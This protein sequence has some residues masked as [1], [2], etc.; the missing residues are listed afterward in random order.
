MKLHFPLYAKILIWFFLNLILLGIAFLVLFS[1]QFPLNLNWFL[2]DT[3]RER[4]DSTRGLIVGDLNSRPQ[5]EWDR[6]LARY[7]EAYRVQFVLYAMDGTRLAGPEVELPGEVRERMSIRWRG[8]RGF[9]GGE[10]DQ[11]ED[12]LRPRFRPWPGQILV[13][14]DAPVRYWLLMRARLDGVGATRTNRVF[15]VAVSNRLTG[16]GLFLDIKPWL[17]LGLGV[18]AFSILFW[19]PF[20]RGITRSIGQMTLATRRIA[21]GH[22]DV[23]V[24]AQRGDELGSLAESINQ[25]AERLNGFVRG[26]KRFLGDVAHELCAPLAKLQMALGIL[27]QQ[28]GE[29]QSA[30]VRAASEKAAQISVLVEELLSFSR[31]GYDMRERKLT[32]TRLRP[33]IEDAIRRE[34]TEGVALEIDCPDDLAAQGDPELLQRA[35]GNLIRNALQHGGCEGK[36]EIRALR[37]GGQVVVRVMDEGP[38][39]P[40]EEI[41]KLFDAFYRVDTSRTR[42]TGGTGLGL[43]IVKQCVEACGGTVSAANRAPRG[44]EV[45]LRLQI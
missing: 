4:I 42:D 28:A 10:P 16:G 26:Q 27:E 35:L 39:V 33:L 23:R 9:A 40:A 13:R 19:L 8:R 41:S 29:T 22:F 44:L 12:E 24:P 31:A 20:V 18:L 21:E 3:A 17:W 2:V 32:S 1:A 38:G 43:T 37:E 7:S 25:M 5:A 34:E 45:I 30:S 11:A 15:L 14:T 36:I 6:V